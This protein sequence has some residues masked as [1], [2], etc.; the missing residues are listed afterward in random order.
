MSKLSLVLDDVNKELYVESSNITFTEIHHNFMNKFSPGWYLGAECTHLNYNESLNEYEI[1]L[2]FR[3]SCCDSDTTVLFI[4]DAKDL[5][6][7][8]YEL[9]EYDESLITHTDINDSKKM[10]YYK[11]LTNK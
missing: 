11:Y 9:L 4:V 3:D 5:S 1:T 2:L 7:N 6:I 8:E 10:N